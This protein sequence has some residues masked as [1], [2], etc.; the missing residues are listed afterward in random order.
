MTRF[1]LGGEVRQAGQAAGAGVGSPAARAVRGRAARPAPTAPR[2]SAESGR[3]S[4]G[5]SACWRSF[6]SRVHR[7][8][9]L[10]GDRL[11]EVQDH[12]GDRRVGGQ[13][14]RVERRVARRLADARS[15]ARGRVGVARGSGA[16]SCSASR[17]A[18]LASSVGPAAAAGR[19]AEGRRRAASSGVAPPSVSIR[20]ARR[21]GGLDVGR[22]RSAGRAPGAACS[23]RASRTMQ[24]S[25]LGGVEGR[26]SP[27]AATVRFQKV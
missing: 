10:L 17:R 5:G 20:S 8:G 24:I 25:R 12:A 27:A 7:A 13:L 15:A 26:P 1:A 16:G 2:P 19:Q 11:V 21:A 3:R 9:S 23:V 22:R 6:A 14:G 4:G 18:G